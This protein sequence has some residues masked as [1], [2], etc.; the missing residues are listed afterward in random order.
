[1][2]DNMITTEDMLA[3]ARREVRQRQRVYPRLVEMGNMAQSEADRET[4]T[5]QAIAEK[6]HRELEADNLFGGVL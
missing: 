4:R 6:L 5:M 2:N 3:C 1:M